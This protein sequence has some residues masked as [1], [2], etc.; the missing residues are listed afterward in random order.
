[1]DDLID[2]ATDFARRRPATVTGL[3]LFAGFAIA[4]FLKA[5][6]DRRDTAMQAHSARRRNQG[7]ASGR[8]PNISSSA[9]TRSA[10]GPSSSGPEGASASPN[11]GTQRN[12][13]D[14]Q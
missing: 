5:S 6:A 13:S 11:S 8:P 14:G 4:R 3:S 2:M 9:N 12:P 1:V 10:G 7:A